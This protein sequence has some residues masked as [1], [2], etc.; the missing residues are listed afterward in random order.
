M[1]PGPSLSLLTRLA[2]DAWSPGI[3]ARLLAPGDVPS[4]SPLRPGFGDR[5]GE[6]YG[7]PQVCSPALPD[8]VASDD[9]GDTLTV[10]IRGAPDGDY[11]VS[12][13]GV[14][15]Y[16]GVSG[17]GPR[18]QPTGNAHRAGGGGEADPLADRLIRFVIPAELSTGAHDVVIDAP[19]GQQ[20]TLV[21]VV[22]VVRRPRRSRDYS[23][24]GLFPAGSYSG[25]RGLSDPPSGEVLDP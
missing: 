7:G 10:G 19:D 12:V 25:L 9:G 17:N 6:Q 18:I 11:Y 1:S 21:G 20:W 14:S 2:P 16:S 22:V 3:S 8:A 15:A 5:F 4:P 24:R 23:L 13:G